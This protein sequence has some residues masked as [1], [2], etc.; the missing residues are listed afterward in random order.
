[1][2]LLSDEWKI[3]LYNSNGTLL[4]HQEAFNNSECV[5]DFE[6]FQSSFYIVKISSGKAMF[7]YKVVKM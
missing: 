4:L 1:M 7:S 3:N 6:K 5:L 2:D